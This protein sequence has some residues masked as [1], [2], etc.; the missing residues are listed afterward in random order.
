M[1]RKRLLFFIESFSGG[2]AERVLLTI[3]R[4]IDL[5]K[6][7]VTVLVI[8]DKGVYQEA[9][10]SLGIKIVKV[11]NGKWPLF[12]KVKYKLVYNYLPPKMALKWLLKGLRADTYIAFI[13]GYCTK[14]LSY[15]TPKKRKIAWVHIDLKNFPWPI[16]K[17]IYKNTQEEK[18]AYSKF[19]LAV[20]VSNDVSDVLRNSYA[21]Q[22]V[23]TIYNPID[24]ERIK[25][26]AKQANNYK[27]DKQSF[28]I[29]SV[30]R[31]T[32][33]KGYDK[34]I[35]EMPG[36]LKQN[37]G[38]KLYIIGDGEERPNLEQQIKDLGLQENVILSGFLD[39]PYSVMKNM[40]LFVCSSV[41]EGFSLVIAEAMTLGLPIASMKCAGPCELLGHGKYGVLC[42]N[43]EE[44]ADALVKI[45]M[46]TSLRA[47]LR[48][49]SQAR[50]K[51]FN[52]K[53]IL[54][55][56]EEIL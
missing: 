25:H 26:L 50:S 53:Q 4:N 55:T 34:L 14:M 10:N 37:P 35:A 1:I 5:S 39:N 48:K 16:E 44:L 7:H 6:F 43:Y 22:T 36:I 8:N 32:R 19:D 15:L 31:L 28:N 27:I 23:K 29:V 13:E 12:D 3:L 56:I 30:G 54:Q 41:A 21:L 49:K 33:Q 18:R 11:L 51:D 42:N 45:S 24:E 52:T 38:I 20:G 47:E 40:N 2:G 17:G 9:F 46:D